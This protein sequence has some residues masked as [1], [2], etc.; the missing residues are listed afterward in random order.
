MIGDAALHRTRM[1]CASGSAAGTLHSSH[2][3]ARPEAEGPSTAGTQQ[4]NGVGRV[5][6]T[7]RS[8]TH[9]RLLAPHR[10]CGTVGQTVIPVPVV[11][12]P[13]SGEV[14]GPRGQTQRSR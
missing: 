7:H 2:T 9:T 4:V 12:A 14:S 11:G 10:A 1:Q 5:S 13:T 6:G 3:L 8:A